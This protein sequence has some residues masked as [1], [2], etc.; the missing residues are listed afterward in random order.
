MAKG[1]RQGAWAFFGEVLKEHREA[2]GLTREE[3]GGLVFVSGAQIGL[4]ERGIRNPQSGAAM[5]IGEIL[6]TGGIFERSCRKPID[7]SPHASPFH[8]AA[9]PGAMATRAGH[10]RRGAASAS[11][12]SPPGRSP[13]RSPRSP[14]SAAFEPYRFHLWKS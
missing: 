9:D 10:R 3:L 2:A 12:R 8:A 7:K 13:A 1:R 11:V 6:Q 5:R 4:F 14:A